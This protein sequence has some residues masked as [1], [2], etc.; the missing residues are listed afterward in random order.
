MVQIGRCEICIVSKSD[1]LCLPRRVTS[2]D[3]EDVKT[4]A[5]QSLGFRVLRGMTAGTQEGNGRSD[6]GGEGRGFMPRKPNSWWQR[7]VPAL[8]H[9]IAKFNRR[10]AA[11]YRLEER[12][13]VEASA[14]GERVVALAGGEVIN[15]TKRFRPV[16]IEVKEGV[17]WLTGSAGKDDIVLQAGDRFDLIGR[18]VFVAQSLAGSAT[19]AVRRCS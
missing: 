18:G 8:R 15:L 13:A 7:I 5:G 3:A 19:I 11:L 10:L 12:S 14:F 4:N 6:I 9:L 1:C 17:I 16:Q 2:G